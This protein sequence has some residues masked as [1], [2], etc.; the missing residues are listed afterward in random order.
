MCHE[1]SVFV[2][3]SSN[4]KTHFLNQAS[5]PDVF[6]SPS[7]PCS[8]QSFNTATLSHGLIKQRLQIK[9]GKR[10]PGTMIMKCFIQLLICQNTTILS[11][12]VFLPQWISQV[13]TQLHMQYLWVLS[14]QIQLITNKNIESNIFVLSTDRVF[15]LLLFLKQFSITTI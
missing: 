15:S 11:S 1:T 4:V 14:L 13:D 9:Q 2:E 12:F 8:P 6:F 7:R 3:L 5:S 10:K